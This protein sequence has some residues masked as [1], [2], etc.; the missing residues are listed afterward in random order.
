MYAL[1]LDKEKKC[2]EFYATNFV[3]VWKESL[4]LNEIVER[5]I[6]LGMEDAGKGADSPEFKILLEALETETSI[7]ENVT[8]KNYP[9]LEKLQVILVGGDIKWNFETR[10]QNLIE[11]ARFFAQFNFQLFSKVDFLQHRTKVLEDIISLK[12]N[13][14]SF[15]TENYRAVNG[16]ELLKKY[17]GGDGARKFSK[18]ETLIKCMES[19]NAN[20]GDWVIV[21]SNLPKGSI[22]P[23]KK[24]N[25]QERSA[26]GGTVQNREELPSS[27][28]KHNRSSTRPPASSKKRRL[29]GMTIGKRVKRDRKRNEGTSPESRDIETQVD[30]IPDHETEELSISEFP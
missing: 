25:E 15:L 26:L 11:S 3:T 5:A 16:D 2:Y 1:K 27:T 7:V 13:Y 20:K 28:E 30:T 18:S 17:K 22:Y 6:S 23:E 24:E 21:K 4:N 12:D 9:L 8:T 14:I 10:E 29:G 19:Y